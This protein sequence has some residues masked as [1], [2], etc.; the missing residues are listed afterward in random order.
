MASIIRNESHGEKSFD[1]FARLFYGGA[2]NGP[3]VKPYTFDQLVQTLNRVVPYGWA[4]FLNK[5]LMSTSAEAP[6]GGIEASGWKLDFTS[7]PTRGG[8][9]TRGF[10]GS[11]FSIGLSL[12]ADGTVSDAIHDGPA[13]EAGISPGMKVVGVNGRVYTAD[14]LADAIKASK[15]TSQAIQLLVIDDD[16]Y[17]T[18][19]VDYH[20]GERYP[21]LV[22]DASK[23]DYL[24]EMLKPLAR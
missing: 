17:K 10:S 7:E 6:L 18:C 14:I 9:T 8:R 20:D 12:A 4:D 16:Y 23:P 2:N 1:D 11:T 21:H 15:N 24:D 3:E 22:R 19:A 5:R 13:F